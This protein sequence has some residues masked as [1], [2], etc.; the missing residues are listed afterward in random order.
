MTQASHH[1][2]IDFRIEIDDDS[3]PLIKI[4]VRIKDQESRLL[5]GRYDVESH[6]LMLVS[7]G[8]VFVNEIQRTL[9]HWKSEAVKS[10]RIVLNF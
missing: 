7:A 1:Y 2:T 9:S 8:E 3:L 4:Y 10:G 5:I 6:N